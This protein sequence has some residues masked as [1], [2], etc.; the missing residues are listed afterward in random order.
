MVD[1]LLQW[2][3]TNLQVVLDWILSVVTDIFSTVIEWISDFPADVFAYLILQPAEYFDLDLGKHLEDSLFTTIF[4]I[5]AFII[6]LNAMITIAAANLAVVLSVRSV[7]WGL[8][9]VP[10]VG[11]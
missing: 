9:L 11:G 6:P 1:R 10:T 8:A 3:Y 4:E 7:R 5:M 2:F